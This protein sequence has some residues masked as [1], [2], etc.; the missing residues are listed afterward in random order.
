MKVDSWI[1]L[2]TRVIEIKF[3]INVRLI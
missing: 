1:Q 3:R 2:G